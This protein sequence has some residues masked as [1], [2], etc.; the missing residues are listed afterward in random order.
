MNGTTAL[1]AAQL[2]L[3]SSVLLLS[4]L[5]VQ[6]V[7]L[8]LSDQ[9]CEVFNQFEDKKHHVS[10]SLHGSYFHMPCTYVRVSTGLMA[11]FILYV[12]CA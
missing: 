9:A 8:Y 5:H 2:E 11:M 1:L 6:A 4:S 3:I 10:S 12:L 7:H